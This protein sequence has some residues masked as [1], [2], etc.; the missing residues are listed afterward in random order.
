MSL[1]ECTND[2]QQAMVTARPSTTTRAHRPRSR[3]VLA[4]TTLAVASSLSASTAFQSAAPLHRRVPTDRATEHPGFHQ[5]TRQWAVTDPDILLRETVR[6]RSLDLEALENAY[7][8][9]SG[10]QDYVFDDDDAVETTGSS[11]LP[12]R[13]KP[14]RKK[15]PKAK[16]TPTVS[17]SSTMPGFATG[18]KSGREKAFQDGIRMVEQQSGKKYVDTLEAKKERRKQSSEAMYKTSAS[19]PDSMLQFASEI[20]LVRMIL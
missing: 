1:S 7:L 14:K 8:S 10:M 17:R 16:N 3:W 9:S 6:R 15:L 5:P 20:H 2:S 19:V 4:T 11:V 13:K 18:V 12:E